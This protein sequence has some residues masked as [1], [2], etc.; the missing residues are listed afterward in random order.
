[1]ASS[2]LFKLNLRDVGNSVITA[3]VIAV[4]GYLANMTSLTSL[5]TSTLF[6]VAILAAVGSLVKA[7]GTDTNGKF[8]GSI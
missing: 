4:C 1:M 2:N 7:L 5:D 8:L 3:V 6:Q